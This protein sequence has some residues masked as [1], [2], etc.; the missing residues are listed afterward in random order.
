[1][2][3]ISASPSLITDLAN[4]VSSAAKN[5]D[6]Q[7]Q[8]QGLPQPSFAPDGPTYVVPKDAPK[9]AHEA[10][11]AT[12]EAALK[13]FNLVSGPSE[14]LPNMTASYHTIFA[15]QWLHHFDVFSRI[16]LDGTVS[17]ET[18]ATEANVP[19]SLLKSVAR[20]AMTSNILAEPTMGQVVHTANS[21][22]FLKFPNTRD[23]ASYMFTASIP[24]AAAMVQATEKWPGSVKK[25]ETAY[26]VAFGHDLPFFDHLSQSPVLTKQFSGYMRS[27]TDGQGM[28][29][30]HLVEGFDWTGLPDNSIVVDIGGS[31]GHASYALASAYP[32]LR[33]EVQDLDAVVNGEKATKEHEEAAKKHVLSADTRVSFKAHNFFEPQ[34]TKDASVYMLRMIIHDWPDAEAKTILSN[35]VPALEAAKAT[36]LVMDTV[37]PSPGSIPSVRER[38]IRTRDLTMRQVFNAKERGV[39]DW[40]ALLR[41]ADSRLTLKNVRQPEGSNM[42]LLTISLQDV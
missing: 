18:L 14:L 33:F 15:L 5:L 19:E 39:D 36:L 10:R 27:V 29:L 42:C 9:V 34:P 13:L 17:Y 22:M 41:D 21:A 24:T 38:V 26:N 20:M 30:S 40:E 25:T 6:E 8:S 3:S 12:A 4:A 35:L 28:D 7:L 31:R 11:V 2:G 23:W 32:H 1:M 16:P 37:L